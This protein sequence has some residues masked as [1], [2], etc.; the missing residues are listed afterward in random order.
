MATILPPDPDGV[1]RAD[2]AGPLHPPQRDAEQHE[3][4]CGIGGHG[5][6]LRPDALQGSEVELPAD[7]DQ[8]ADSGRDQR[9]PPRRPK[10]SPGQDR[11]GRFAARWRRVGAGG[12][13]PGNHHG[14]RPPA[15]DGFDSQP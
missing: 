3:T 4:Q 10:Q 13:K 1:A 11:L 9:A 15:G 14:N 2:A 8:R 7:Q 6:Q 5:A 12:G